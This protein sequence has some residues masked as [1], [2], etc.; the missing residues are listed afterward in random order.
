MITPAKDFIDSLLNQISER[1]LQR[2][3]ANLS[4][5]DE[6]KDNIAI[7]DGLR[8]LADIINDQI[9]EDQDEL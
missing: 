5:E 1:G 6:H 8:E 7:R 4:N 9:E 3:A 2:K